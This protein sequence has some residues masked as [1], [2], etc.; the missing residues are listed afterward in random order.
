MDVCD[1]SSDGDDPEWVIDN[2][3]G[4]YNHRVP[5]KSTQRFFLLEWMDYEGFYW[6]YESVC[7]DYDSR[8]V[9]NYCN[10]VSV[11]N[12]TGEWIV[13]NTNHNRG[14][15]GSDEKP[16]LTGVEPGAVLKETAFSQD[17]S[18]S[19]VDAVPASLLSHENKEQ[20]DDILLGVGEDDDIN[21]VAANQTSDDSEEEL[22]PVDLMQGFRLI[23]HVR[24]VRLM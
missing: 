5:G 20:A 17:I 21:D 23:L 13:P 16:W 2:I 14:Y 1:G 18:M 8:K 22:S 15:F 6:E 3:V 11:Q 19:L 12:A 9:D 24:Y 7:R 4:V 10:R